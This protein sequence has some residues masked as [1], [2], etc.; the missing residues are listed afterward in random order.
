MIKTEDVPHLTL[1]RTC[2]FTPYDGRGLAHVLVR[3]AALLLTFFSIETQLTGRVE[4][5]AQHGEE[6][7]QYQLNILIICLLSY[8]PGCA[9]AYTAAS[10]PCPPK[11][12]KYR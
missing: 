12:G 7:G 4:C 1:Y 8:I 6:L 9:P 10:Y 5:E 2:V 11:P 3:R